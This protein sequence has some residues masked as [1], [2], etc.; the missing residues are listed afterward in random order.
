MAKGEKKKA[1]ELM[2]NALDIKS[3]LPN[4][5]HNS[6]TAAITFQCPNQ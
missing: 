3:S 5:L 6:G 1:V 2:R 4:A